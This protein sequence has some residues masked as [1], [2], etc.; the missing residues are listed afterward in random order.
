MGIEQLDPSLGLDLPE[1]Y[2]RH[3]LRHF[4]RW[5]RVDF[6]VANAEAI[7]VPDNSADDRLFR[8]TVANPSAIA[9]KKAGI[10]SVRDK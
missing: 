7:P 5:T 8:V 2:I 1:A 10:S 9:D 3:A 6:V 4:R